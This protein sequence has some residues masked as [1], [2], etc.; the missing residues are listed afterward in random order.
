MLQI[1]S[2]L[3]SRDDRPW[4]EEIVPFLDLSMIVRFI[5]EI[6]LK[7]VADLR[8]LHDRDRFKI[9][10]FLL[11]RSQNIYKFIVQ[12]D[13]IESPNPYASFHERQNDHP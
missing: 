1:Y 10:Y 6:N 5:E 9:F 3:E 11:R 7:I 8:R 2:G 13:S 4:Q 12:T